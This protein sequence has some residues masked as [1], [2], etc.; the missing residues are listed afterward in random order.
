MW[1]TGDRD[2]PDASDGADDRSLPERTA[3]RRVVLVVYAVVVAIAGVMGGLLGLVA[4]MGMDPT[5]VVV[6]LPATPLGM[7]AFGVVTVGGGLGLL[8]LGVRAVSQFDDR[9]MR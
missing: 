8:L 2:G 5:L 3:G 7:V 9:R 6:D 4:P 1:T